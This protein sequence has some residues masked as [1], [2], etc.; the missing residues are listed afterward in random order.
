[1]AQISQESVEELLHFSSLL[2]LL[3]TGRKKGG[4]VCKS[5][6]TENGVTIILCLP[7]PSLS[8]CGWQGVQSNIRKLDFTQ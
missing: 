2:F 8:Q 1:M 6:N 7:S 4:K 5:P 3:R